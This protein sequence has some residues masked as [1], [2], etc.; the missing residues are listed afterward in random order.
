MTVINVLEKLITVGLQSRQWDSTAFKL[1]IQKRQE[2]E[3]TKL[4]QNNLFFLQ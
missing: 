1:M 2:T 3:V 4:S